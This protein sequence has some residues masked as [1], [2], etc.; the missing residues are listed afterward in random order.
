MEALLILFALALLVGSVLGWVSFLKIRS[1]TRDI[2]TLR[3]HLNNFEQ[4]IDLKARPVTDIARDIERELIESGSPVPEPTP[5]SS[6]PESTLPTSKEAGIGSST[7]REN[8]WSGPEQQDT[9]EATTARDDTEKTTNLPAGL[10]SRLQDQWMVWLGGISVGLSGIF[11]VRYSIE[12]GL[13][14]PTARILLSLFFGIAL[15]ALAELGR[16]RNV[17]QNQALAA[18]AGGASVILYAALL[19]A[20]LLYDLVS[21]GP[22]FIALIIV[23]L[24]TM[25]L[26]VLHGPVLAI[27]GIL[28]AYV[29]PLLVDTGSDSILGLF[30]YSLIISSAAILLMHY[31]YRIWLWG[32][33]V[34]GA[35][36]WWFLS[37]PNNDAE[38]Y[39][40]YYLAA[41]AYLFL[42]L[43]AW[44][45]LL[46]KTDPQESMVS[47]SAVDTSGIARAPVFYTLALIVLAFGLSIA[48]AASH[49]LAIVQWTPLVAICLIAAGSR[50]SLLR[51]ALGSLLIQLLAWLSLGL[52]ASNGIQLEGLVGPEQPG[53]ILYAAWMAFVYVALCLRN[54]MQGRNQSFWF[55]FALI[56]PLAWLSLCY[57]LV[58]DLSQ[59]VYW[60]AISVALGVFYLGMAGWRLRQAGN[61]EATADTE[62]EMYTVWLILAGHFAYSLAV[63]II[64]REAGLTLALSTQLLSIAWVIRRFNLP[65]LG[66]LLK[67][68]LAIVVVRLTLNPWLLTYAADIHWSLWTYGGAAIFCGLATWQLRHDSELG[69]WL[70]AATLHLIVLTLWAETRYWLYDGEIFR[71]Q[72]DMLEFAINT[73]L[74]STLGL[75]YYQR[76][77]VSHN[78]KSL[79]LLASKVLLVMGLGSYLI[80]LIPLNPLLSGEQIS[81]TPLINTLLLAYGYP[82]VI[83]ALLFKFYAASAR[84]QIGIFAGFSAFVFV[85]L[86]IRHLWQGGLSLSD[87]T[88]SGELYTYTIVWL[89]MSVACLLAGSIR[90]GNS[91]YKAGFG[92]MM[93]VI[94]KIFLLDM[95]D[96]E[97]L[98]RVAS[99]MGLGLS[100]LGLAYLYQRFNLSPKAPVKA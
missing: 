16:R 39:R 94:G 90:Y 30:V 62:K 46:K 33:T 61:P 58:S 6:K 52:I 29:I 38:G 69:K 81:S 96:L 4:R 48:G 10:I 14:S 95:A 51:V 8:V 72:A 11:M 92:L 75:V 40:G 70:E 63:A 93:L 65:R 22:V 31:V 76:H 80:V 27:L 49:S 47:N 68:V 9:K 54:L 50:D 20:L 82:I 88:S 17:Q 100:L 85:S 44:D 73:A 12:Q 43:P 36:G 1:L 2:G 99:F 42:A 77:K 86:E 91:V 18:L 37:L 60:G 35:L 53:F 26:A 66:L 55:A 74:W 98:L 23:S 24:A 59:S 45:W 78:L 19:A 15:H 89:V 32:Y 97:G 28:G 57:L 67:V 21:P 71:Q 3:K 7:V 25:A 64:F 56:S 34:A 84:K 5:A 13:M 83:S 87:F 79:Y 41:L